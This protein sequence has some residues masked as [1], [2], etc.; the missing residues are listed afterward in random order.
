M[1]TEVRNLSNLSLTESRVSSEMRHA[2]NA[3][4]GGVVWF[5]GLPS[6]GKSTMAIELERALFERG[7]QVFVLDGD[8]LR[9]GLNVDLG[10]S[11]H[12]RTENIRRVGQVAALFAEAGFIAIAA[13]ISPYRTDRAAGRAAAAGLQFHEIFCNANLAVCEGRDPKGHYDKARRGEIPD[14]TGISAP[15]EMPEECELVVDTGRATIR[16]CLNKLV[17][18][19]TTHFPIGDKLLDKRQLDRRRLPDSAVSD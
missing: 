3:H 14:F 7:Y 9:Q 13:F 4:T 11:P 8:N 18:H 15:Y 2:R 1:G 17:R 5:T 19:M 12:D 6:S 10:F 16:Q